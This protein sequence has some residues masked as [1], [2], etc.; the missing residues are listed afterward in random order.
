M[1]KM[2]KI[3]KRYDK[4]VEQKHQVTTP[5]EHTRNGDAHR[6]HENGSA[7]QVQS[8]AG[9]RFSE[10]SSVETREHYERKLQRTKRRGSDKR[11]TGE[12]RQLKVCFLEIFS[13]KLAGSISGATV[14]PGSNV[15]FGVDCPESLGSFFLVF[16]ID[17]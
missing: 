9:G 16:Q 6:G 12:K 5:K 17:F 3:V 1:D 10:S 14:P 8:P 4:T 13:K 15:R 11:R 2:F 7:V